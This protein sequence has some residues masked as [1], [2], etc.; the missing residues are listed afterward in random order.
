MMP[1][2]IQSIVVNPA[3]LSTLQPFGSGGARV[4]VFVQQAQV[5]QCQANGVLC[6]PINRQASPQQP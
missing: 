1:T 3:T 2:S 5:I 6:L 4:A